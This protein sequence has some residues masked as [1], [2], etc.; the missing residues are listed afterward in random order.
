MVW[1]DAAEFP[2]AGSETLIVI[3]QWSTEVLPCRMNAFAGTGLYGGILALTTLTVVPP[4][5]IKLITSA[6]A[7]ACADVTVKEVLPRIFIA[8]ILV[9]N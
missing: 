6:S 7:M 4:A 1:V 5:L 3:T 2:W 9:S 8:L